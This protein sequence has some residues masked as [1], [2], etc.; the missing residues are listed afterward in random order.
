MY[1]EISSPMAGTE[2]YLK[3]IESLFKVVQNLCLAHSLEEITKVVLAAVRELTGSEGATFV[4]LDNGFSYYVDENA[5]AHLWKGQRFPI[6]TC[7]GGWVMLNRKAA[8]ID[9]VSDD[10]RISRAVYQDTFVKSMAMVPIGTDE[11]IGAIGTYWLQQHQAT[12]EQ[13]KLLQLLADCTAAAMANAQIYSQM[14]RQLRDRTTALENTKAR[15]QQEIQERKSMEA[16]ARLLSLTDELTGLNNRRGFYL[17][18]EQQLRLAKRSQVYLSLMFIELNGLVKIQ[19]T[20][21]TRFSQ[22]AIVATARLLKRS[23]R[24]SD[25]LGRV[26]EDEFVVLIQGYDPDFQIIQQRVETN[27]IQFNQT[28]QF[29]FPLTLNIGIQPYD[30]NQPISLNDLIRL[31]HLH[32]YQNKGIG[33]RE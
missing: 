13:V 16:E 10:P 29:P 25:T 3:S 6:N 14:E 19:E 4:I 11:P 8:I 23:F 24:N 5:I 20:Y 7:I 26:S 30:F 28:Q 32:I 27:I 18:A 9:D 12:T 2:Y 15:L 21:G 1:I 33:N 17:L 31:A 22:D